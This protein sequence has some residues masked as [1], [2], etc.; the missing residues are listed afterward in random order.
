MQRADDSAFDAHTESVVGRSGVGKPESPELDLTAAQRAMWFAERLSGDYSVNIAQYLDITH[1]GSLDHG[2]LARCSIEAGQAMESPYLRILDVDGVPRQQVDLDLPIEVDT[3]DFRAH[4]DPLGDAMAHM[5]SDHR[6]SVDLLGDLLVVSTLI[7]VADDRTFWYMRGHHIVIDGYAALTMIRMAVDR[8]NAIRRGE[9]LSEKPIATMAEIVADD[10]KYQASSRRETDGEHWR[11]RVVDLPE[12]VTLSHRDENT[13]LRAD[14][15]VVGGT[16]PTELQERLVS[17]SA[18]L[19][20][21]MA[22]TVTA[23]FGAFLSRMTGRDD[24]VLTLPVTGRA[25]AKIKRGGGMVSNVLPIRLATDGDAGVTELIEQTQ[26]ELT[27]ALRHQ[28]YR[29]DDIWRA[30]G[31][32]DG[33]YAFGPVINMMFF[34]QPI[35]LDGAEVEYH[36]LTSGMLEDLLLNLYQASPGAPLVIDLHGNA[37]RYDDAEMHDHH[38]RFLL[39]L[40]GFLDAAVRE[41]GLLADV[42]LLTAA[43]AERNA[44]QSGPVPAQSRLLTDV[45]AETVR[46]HEHVPA[47]TDVDGETLTY[48][49]LDRRANQMARWLIEHGAGPEVLV[50][51]ALPRSVDLLVA[52]WAVLKSGAAFVP[53]DP[54]HPADRIAHMIADSG[55]ELGICGDTDAGLP[56]L[57]RPWLP[58][59]H[60][61]SAGRIAITPSSPLRADERP[62]LH[63]DNLAY[64]IYTSGST[65][66]PK[67]TPVTHRGV[68]N[69][70]VEITRR[71]ETPVGARV[72]GYASPSFDASIADIVQV[73]YAGAT[74]VN[75]PVAALGGEDLADVMREQDITHASL[76]PTVLATL[77]PE[78]V[79]GLHTV[80]VAGEAV[81]QALIDAWGGPGSRGEVELINGYG[82]TEASVGVSYTSPLR[83][84][85]RAHLGEP[86]A[87]TSFSVLDARMRPVPDGVAGEL[88]LAGIGLSR[89]YLGRPG[90]TAGRFVA[91]PFGAAGERLY[92]T[93]DLVRRSTGP[94]GRTVV[95]FV[96]RTDFQLKLRG[97]RIEPGEIEAVISSYPGVESSAVLGVDATGSVTTTAAVRV[98]EL[99][100]YVVA[101]DD[102]SDEALQDFVAQRVPRYMVPALYTRIDAMPRTPTGKLDRRGLPDPETPPERAAVEYVAPRTELERHLVDAVA[103]LIEMP[104]D[105]ADQ[106][107]IGMHDNL[108]RIGADSLTASRLAST[109]RRRLAVDV[110]L[111]DVFASADLADLA[112]RIAAQGPSLDGPV[113][114]DRPRQPRPDVLP[115][116]H[117]Q[118]RLW[119]VNRMEPGSP[120]YNMPGAVRFRSGVD[121]AAMSAA[122]M[123]L[124]ARHEPLRTRFPSR[125]GE[126]IQEI[127][128][129]ADVVADM[130]L[131]VE[132]VQ[133]SAIGEIVGAQAHR[134]FDLTTQIPFRASMFELEDGSHVLV[135]V[136]HHIAGDGASM[137]PLIGDLLHAYHART[138]GAEPSWPPLAIQYADYALEQRSA[139]GDP[140][141]PQSALAGHLDFWSAELSGLPELLAV[142]TDHSRPRI[143]S[144]RGDYV[145]VDID[146]DLIG[147]LSALAA[148]NGVTLFTAL[149]AGLAILLGRLAETDD[150]AIGTAIAGRDDPRVAGLIGMFVNTVVLRSNVEPAQSVNEFL[151]AGHRARAAAMDHSDV[152]FEQIVEHVAPSR[153]VSHAPLFQ[154]AMTMQDDETGML[155][156]AGF[157]VH[158]LDARVPAAKFDL[159]FT[160]VRRPVGGQ[161]ELEIS[162]ATDLFDESTVRR[163]AGRLVT[164]L[165]AMVL[166]PHA[167][168]GSIDVLDADEVAQ[169]TALPRSLPARTFGEILATGASAAA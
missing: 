154:V 86:I 9:Q 2:L 123:D 37:N 143:A 25:S 131:Q 78:S 53:V 48:G 81:G 66:R 19:N 17:V 62:P 90:L 115:L 125:D 63:V 167:P 111:T 153:S 27:G 6:R 34:D 135:I 30:S 21:S 88:Y 157:D 126:P 117:A 28:R 71:V 145:D 96:G 20:T 146:A 26:L 72:L 164:V 49:Q 121:I 129:V 55:V 4:A 36:I 163:M 50:A 73:T 41:N 150:V 22:V 161:V 83:I 136:L 168:I 156:A 87:G 160:A 47:V 7:R 165:R 169:V 122:L 128:D 3:L 74:L 112:E 61:T 113:D 1:D 82:P 104:A 91:N 134:G 119:F 116:S 166:R 140:D 75:R 40:N 32:G 56:D 80:I 79:R 149:H 137:A 152:P 29:S 98:V 58:L 24:V 138:A 109:L 15:V 52:I 94:D 132:R 60:H 46:T 23:A 110:S 76:T 5:R 100:A 67:G 141:D 142:P 45:F 57:P 44:V 70:G 31:V 18:E 102:V 106:G 147:E 77:A 11:S 10:V 39:F 151:V 51:L 68:H 120:T 103:A 105:P 108:F 159:S 144:G 14:N 42:A 124:L 130:P 84:G 139:L 8:Y 43:D 155:G 13:D 158:L 93:G 107:R 92:R 114:Q 38:A 12:R 59:R 69:L 101:A 16:L 54:T 35:A 65:G 162:Y 64:V 85:D 118:T 97:Q 99:A 133:E 89:G 33:S 127:L 148:A 95:E